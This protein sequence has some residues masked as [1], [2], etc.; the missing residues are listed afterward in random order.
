[1]DSNI[2][3]PTL[4]KLKHFKY[5]SP[6]NHKCSTMYI[7]NFTLHSDFKIKYIHEEAKVF[8][9]HFDAKYFYSNPLIYDL[10]TFTL[11]GSPIKH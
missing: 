2:L 5:D 7:T 11:T 4:T 9:K 3:F 1:M 8:Y 6:E 10:A